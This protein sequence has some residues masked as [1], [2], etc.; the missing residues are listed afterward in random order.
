MEWNDYVEVGD[1]DSLSPSRPNYL[2][3]SF[4]VK[5]NSLGNTGFVWRGWYDYIVYGA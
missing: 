4:W 5:P 3:L 2:F 1:S